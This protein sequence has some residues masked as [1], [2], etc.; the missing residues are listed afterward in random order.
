L[1]NDKGLTLIVGLGN[2]GVAY[3][4]TRHNI[5]FMV[6]DAFAEK[7]ALAFKANSALHGK[8][9]IGKVEGSDCILLKPS[10]Y[11]NESGRAVKQCIDS[12]KPQ[13]L[14]VICD[15]IALPFGKMRIREKGSSGGHNGLKNIEAHLHSALYPRFRIGVG[16]PGCGH[17]KEYVLSAFSKEEAL[18]L[19][20]LIVRA[21]EALELWMAAG[22]VAAM[23]FA[24]VQEG[25]G[26]QPSQDKGE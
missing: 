8:V 11:M 16:H 4:K 3:K 21:V 24:N 13:R 12:Y 5:G 7:H 14:M 10:T 26:E 22:I 23:R 18:A 2:P 6:L 25:K 15:D 17:V 19:E 20:E 9:A 1:P